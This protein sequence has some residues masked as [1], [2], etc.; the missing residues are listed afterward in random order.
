MEEKEILK[1]AKKFNDEYVAIEKIGKWEGFTVYNPIRKGKGVAYT[2]YPL[3]LLV[4]EGKIRW[5]SPKEAID[6]FRTQTKNQN[7]FEQ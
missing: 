2:G 5:T 6:I 7:K 4:K 3:K 1:F